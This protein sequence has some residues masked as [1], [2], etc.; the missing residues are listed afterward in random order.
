MYVY[1]DAKK[2]MLWKKSIVHKT[3]TMA[4]IE[5]GSLM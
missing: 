1:L 4:E 2:K 3:T 5:G